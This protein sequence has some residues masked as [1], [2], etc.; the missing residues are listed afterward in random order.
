GLSVAAQVA[1]WLYVATGGVVGHARLDL[2]M[3]VPIIVSVA[4][5]YCLNTGLVAAAIAVTTNS[6]LRAVWETNYRW[7]AAIYLGLGLIGF[8]MAAAADVIGPLGLTIALV[9]LA[10][11]WYSY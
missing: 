7:L 5:R 3:L 4:A 1:G 2:D 10:I 6:S 8:G 11:A 9:P